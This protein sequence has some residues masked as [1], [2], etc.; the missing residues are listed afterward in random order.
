M[1]LYIAIGERI[2]MYD[3]LAALVGHDIT[4]TYLKVR[5][6]PNEKATGLVEYVYPWTGRM[7]I[8]LTD[9]CLS[10]VKELNG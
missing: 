9:V 7:E 10:L 6:T 1:E 5:Y 8:K 2:V 4:F 3:E